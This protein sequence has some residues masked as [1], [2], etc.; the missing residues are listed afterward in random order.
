M[1]RERAMAM[2]LLSLAASAGAQ[3]AS[4]QRE[5]R[6]WIFG[7]GVTAGQI[8]FSNAEGLEVAVGPMT[9]AI[10]LPYGAGVVEQRAGQVIDLSTPPPPET[11]KV[12]KFPRASPF[13][14]AMRSPRGGP[15]WPSSTSWPPTTTDS[16]S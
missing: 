11:V 10:V 12:A 3:D 15:S 2:L 7:G 6:G 5:G 13:T 4:T 1:A 16:T 8:Q 9:G 14:A